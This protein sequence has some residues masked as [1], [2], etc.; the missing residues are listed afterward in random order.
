VLHVLVCMT[1][2]RLHV[3]LS[4]VVMIIVHLNAVPVQ[5][6]TMVTIF[7]ATVHGRVR[8]DVNLLQCHLFAKRQP[9]RLLK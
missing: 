6:A 9:V 2:R 3:G 8:A 1:M 7:R 5:L 4:V